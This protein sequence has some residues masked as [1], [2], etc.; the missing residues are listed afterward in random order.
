ME[1]PDGFNDC[2]GRV[3]KLNRAIYGLKQAGRQW[4]KK[5][6]DSLIGF[7]LKKSESDPCVFFCARKPLII[8]VYV[9]DMLILYEKSE[10]LREVRDYIQ[11]KL[12]IKDIGHA[13]ECIGIRINQSR[14]KIEIDQ[15]K[16][17]VELLK[18]YNMIDCKSVKT[19]SDPNHFNPQSLN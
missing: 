1:Q 14:T 5:L 16:Y 9:D 17:I 3:C 12:N 2:S 4:N 13:T 8:L 10:D 19:P 6:N 18:K 7:G 11:S 15:Q